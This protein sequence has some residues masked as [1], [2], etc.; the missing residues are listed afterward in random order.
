MDRVKTAA[1]ITVL[2]VFALSADALV[3][4]AEY[5]MHRASFHPAYLGLVA[6]LIGP[7]LILAAIALRV[8]RAVVLLVP[9]IVVV[10]LHG[11]A[12]AALAESHS[13]VDVAFIIPYR[14]ASQYVVIVPGLLIGWGLAPALTR[15]SS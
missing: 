13:W 15:R 1:S 14:T 9:L 2:G 4:P 5:G 10:T 3:G 8:S 6:Y 7:Y 11:I 12:M